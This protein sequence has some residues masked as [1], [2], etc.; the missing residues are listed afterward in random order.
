[1]VWSSQ[2]L[3][4]HDVKG[5]RSALSGGIGSESAATNLTGPFFKPPLNIKIGIVTINRSMHPGV[6]SRHISVA[7]V[8]RHS[9][10]L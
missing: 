9:T 2:K 10:E 6:A 5:S 3:V 7:R 8:V 1:M 4:D